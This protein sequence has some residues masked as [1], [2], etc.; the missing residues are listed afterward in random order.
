MELILPEYDP[1]I[2]EFVAEE[3][4]PDELKQFKKQL[5]MFLR[6]S[7]KY[8]S[9]GTLARF[10]GTDSSTLRKLMTPKDYKEIN[11]KRAQTIL[12]LKPIDEADSDYLRFQAG[13]L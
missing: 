3:K 4:I 1:D 7:A 2:L 5:T 6:Q 9:I 8:Y 11:T 13:T 10:L 12:V